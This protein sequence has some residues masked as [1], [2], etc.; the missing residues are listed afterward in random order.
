M[1]YQL[2][3]PNQHAKRCPYIHAFDH[4]PG[5]PAARALQAAGRAVEV[6]ELLFTELYPADKSRI[7]TRPFK[8]G[9][10]WLPLARPERMEDFANPRKV[11]SLASLT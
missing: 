9:E 10:L 7:R 8:E 2:A 6:G 11:R 5:S 3:R 1:C 4:V